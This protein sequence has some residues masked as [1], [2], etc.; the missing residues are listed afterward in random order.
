MNFTLGEWNGLVVKEIEIL[1]NTQAEPFKIIY[2]TE[3]GGL[4]H[5]HYYYDLLNF[6][7]P[8]KSKPINTFL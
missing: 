6:Y 4:K 2:R 7:L 5:L 8:V 1:E 3:K